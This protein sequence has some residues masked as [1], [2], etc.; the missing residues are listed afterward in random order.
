MIVIK[1]EKH[2][3]YDQCIETHVS[4]VG[5]CV[6]YERLPIVKSDWWSHVKSDWWSK[7]SCVV[8]GI[9]CRVFVVAL[10]MH[11]F[12]QGDGLLLS[13]CNHADTGV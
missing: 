5:P 10:S 12:I 2:V 4:I 9:A 11:V 8:P 1:V 3:E 6:Y 13:I 7:G